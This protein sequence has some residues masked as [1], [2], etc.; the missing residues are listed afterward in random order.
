MLPP[1][2]EERW[3]AFDVMGWNVA[4]VPVKNDDD[5]ANDC[6][7][8]FVRPEGEHEIQSSNLEWDS[9]DFEKEEVLANLQMTSDA[10]AINLFAAL[11]VPMDRSHHEAE[12]VVEPVISNT[13]EAA[14]HRL[15]H[16]HFRD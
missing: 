4:N 1:D 15:Q 9:E 16:N 14:R 5:N 12:S 11:Q 7:W 13:N 3:Y 10:F 8:N 6:H 2:S